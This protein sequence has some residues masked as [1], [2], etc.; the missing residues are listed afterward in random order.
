MEIQN[1]VS[2]NK[3]CIPCPVR[4]NNVDKCLTM[5]LEFFAL[6]YPVSSNEFL[7]ICKVNTCLL[8]Y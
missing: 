8:L 5:C 6:L 2:F 3:T 1:L 4:D 7:D